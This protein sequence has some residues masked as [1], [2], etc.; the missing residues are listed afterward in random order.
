MCNYTH[1]EQNNEQALLPQWGCLVNYL[2]QGK[3]IFLY[4]AFQ[5]K[6]VWIIFW[7]MLYVRK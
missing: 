7:G 6:K 2:L 1:R 4:S 3:I 5:K